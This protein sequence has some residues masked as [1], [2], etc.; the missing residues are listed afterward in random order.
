MWYNDPMA[1]AKKK[2]TKK[3]S[4]ADAAAA[5]PTI[6][7]VQAVNRS[8][9]GQWMHERRQLLKTGGIIGLILL[10]IV[11]VISGIVSLF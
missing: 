5:R 9:L 6:T 2:R 7:R 4:G 10:V 1:K 11:L 8:Q 3:Y